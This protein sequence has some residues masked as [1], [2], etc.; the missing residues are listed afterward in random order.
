MS[1]L[2]A[3][4]PTDLDHEPTERDRGPLTDEQREALARMAVSG[5]PP[6]MIARS[7]R[8]NP[9]TVSRLLRDDEDIKRRVEELS[10]QALRQV[11]IHHTSLMEMLSD[12]R[13]VY[14]EALRG[15]DLRL[16]FEVARH[17]EQRLIP[18]PAA[19]SKTT[20]DVN[21][22]GQVAHEVTGSL[23]AIAA[24]LVELGGSAANPMLSIR[25]GKDA[26][27]GPQALIAQQAEPTL[28]PEQVERDRLDQL[29][30]DHY[31]GD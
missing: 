13:Q 2:D 3:I 4:Y 21:V 6:G 12:C 5:L 17:I 7:L 27:P 30:R 26:L 20:V 14:S 9:K 28:D 23:Q 22:Q 24:H 25:S 1:T 29:E 19:E 16:R 11:A 15:G 10:S 31:K 8:R 18:A